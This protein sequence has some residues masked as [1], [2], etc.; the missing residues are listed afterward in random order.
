MGI[1]GNLVTLARYVELFFF[2][3]LS[4]DEV[5]VDAEVLLDIIAVL[6]LKSRH[7]CHLF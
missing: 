2:L 1:G 7:A 5:L 3:G 4:A 6:V